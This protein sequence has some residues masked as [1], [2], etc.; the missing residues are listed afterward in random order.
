MCAARS[1]QRAA[2]APREQHPTTAPA[3]THRPRVRPGGWT[4]LPQSVY[5]GRAVGDE[6]SLAPWRLRVSEECPLGHRSPT[7][8]PKRRYVQGGV[9]SSG[10]K[11]SAL[12]AARWRLRWGRRTDRDRQSW[13]YVECDRRRGSARL[14]GGVGSRLAKGFVST[15]TGCSRGGCL[16]ELLREGGAAGGGF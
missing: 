13:H 11:A 9:E 6:G 2:R 14:C 16:Q 8:Q 10:A 7:T 15:G 1:R 12:L 3:P 5:P 4:A